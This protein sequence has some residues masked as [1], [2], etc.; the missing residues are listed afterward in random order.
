MSLGFP[1]ELI[2][3]LIDIYCQALEQKGEEEKYEKCILI[4][5]KLRVIVGFIVGDFETKKLIAQTWGLEIV[6]KPVFDDFK[7]AYNFS[8]D[9]ALIVWDATK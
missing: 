7:V 4:T 3:D 5:E 8:K 2:A 1:L 9:G 6:I